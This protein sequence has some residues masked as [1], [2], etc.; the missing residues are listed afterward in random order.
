MQCKLHSTADPKFIL[1]QPSARHEEK[2]D[3]LAREM[4]MIGQAADC[5]FAMAAFDTT[6]WARALMPWSD[7]AVSRDPQVGLHAK[8]TLRFIEHELLPWL[9]RRYGDLPCIIGG[10]SLGG[11][12]RP[13][14]S[15]R[16]GRVP[17]CCRRVAVAVD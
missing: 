7:S 13:M 1:I 16:I 10:Y 3:G 11:T 12:L 14:G 6:D 9:R 4:G 8:E 5:G 17:R 2:A 15:S